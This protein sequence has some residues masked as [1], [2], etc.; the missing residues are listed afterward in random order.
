MKEKKTQKFI[1]ALNALWNTRPAMTTLQR[2]LFACGLLDVFITVGHEKEAPRLGEIYKTFCR[3][4]IDHNLDNL[5]HRFN[6]EGK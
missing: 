5:E 6:R 3:A 4:Q 2:Q 1:N